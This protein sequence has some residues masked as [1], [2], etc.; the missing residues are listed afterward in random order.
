MDPR[1]RM[2]MM[3][4]LRRLAAQG[5]TIL[6]STH[7][8]EELHHLANNVLVVVAGRLAASRP[9]PRDPPADDR[10]AAHLHASAPATTAAWRASSSARR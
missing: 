8:L 5:R 9:L 4:L 2:H 3:D 10:P 1:Q 6:I 7:I